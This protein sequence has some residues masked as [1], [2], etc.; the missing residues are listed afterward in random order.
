LTIREE[1]HWPRYSPLHCAEPH[2]IS[3]LMNAVQQC[4]QFLKAFLADERSMVVAMKGDW[5]VGKTHL[6]KRFI[7]ANESK[8]MAKGYAYASL[9]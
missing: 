1:E 7:A 8:V 2:G 4:E 6:W 9:F 3:A 5:G